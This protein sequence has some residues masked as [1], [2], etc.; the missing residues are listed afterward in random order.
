MTAKSHSTDPI[1]TIA[2]LEVDCILFAKTRLRSSQWSSFVASAR[3]QRLRRTGRPQ[4]SISEPPNPHHT[5]GQSEREG[6]RAGR[7]G[8]PCR[9]VRPQGA[10]NTTRIPGAVLAKSLGEPKAKPAYTVSS[11]KCCF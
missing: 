2:R 11:T 8:S 6:H 10:R 7:H 3:M 5:I 1:F 9:M 4:V